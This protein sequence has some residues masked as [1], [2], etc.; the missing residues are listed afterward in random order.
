MD[1]IYSVCQEKYR[2]ENQE[3]LKF[4][5]NLIIQIYTQCTLHCHF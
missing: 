2:G 3:S 4:L 5:K 1:S